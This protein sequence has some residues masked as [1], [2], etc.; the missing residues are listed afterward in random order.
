MANNYKIK[1]IQDNLSTL[2][3][4]SN[5]LLSKRGQS[6]SVNLRLIYNVASKDYIQPK[7][8]RLEKQIYRLKQ[9]NRF[10][11]S[12]QKDNPPLNVDGAKEYPIPEILQGA[13]IKLIHNKFAIRDEKT[14]SCNYYKDSNS[15]YDFGSAEGGDSVDLYMKI[16]GCNFVEAVRMLA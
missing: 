10:L 14:P 13:G 7:I 1:A 9:Q 8:N 3:D 16:Y 5:R 15:Y 11:S 6:T 4:E 2:N 12:D